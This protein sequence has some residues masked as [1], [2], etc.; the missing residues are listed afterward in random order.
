MFPHM[1]EFPMTV[2]MPKNSTV[3][4]LGLVVVGISPEVRIISTTETM[5][6]CGSYHTWDSRKL[7]FVYFFFLILFTYKEES[8]FIPDMRAM[9]Q[10]SGEDVEPVVGL[11]RKRPNLL[12]ELREEEEKEYEKNNDAFNEN[13]KAQNVDA[14]SRVPPSVEKG[15]LTT[16]P[17]A[18]TVFETRL[19]G[20]GI[21][22]P[23]DHPR[24]I[25][26][27]EEQKEITPSKRKI[28]Y[29]DL[30]GNVKHSLSVHNIKMRGTSAEVAAERKAAGHVKTSAA[31]MGRDQMHALEGCAIHLLLAHIKTVLDKEECAE[32]SFEPVFDG[33]RA[34]L[35]AHHSSF[36]EVY[37][38]IQIKSAQ[39]QFGKQT[40]YSL[41]KGNYEDWMYCISIGIRNYVLVEPENVD[42]TNVPGA[43]IY[44]MW[45][46]GVCVNL[47]P[48]PATTYGPV[49]PAKRC[50]F[51]HD[52][53]GYAKPDAFI[54][55]MLENI[56]AWKH[57]F[58]SDQILYDTEVVNK[59]KID[60]KKKKEVRGLAEL[61]KALPGLRAP[62]RQN[63]TVDSVWERMGISNKTASIA[64]KIPTQRFFMLKVHKY[65]HFCHWVIASYE[66]KNRPD[67]NY[68]KVAVIPAASVYRNE[69]K[70]FCWNE[71]KSST[72]K[73]VKLFDL[74]TEGDAL[75][76]HL[77]TK[78]GVS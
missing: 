34:D 54:R 70:Y 7:Y 63:E 56:K 72:M 32:W 62:W 43:K 48:R 50:F 37:V 33:L 39:I 27:W 40:N 68:K 69:N 66:D 53:E 36:P 67:K 26:F 21:P 29:T 17:I 15:T 28:L 73:D 78:S 45:D 41:Q 71:L 49:E 6:R 22:L 44:E 4:D 30:E 75:R 55:Q 64:N 13:R 51:I 60:E 46:L 76:K 10:S 8:R 19:V 61:A 52:A 1:P 14:R 35:M 25:K 12:H 9:E 77:L 20:K 57:R 3:H 58:T 38:P 59:K 11:K 23:P 47:Q 2:E 24:Q 5:C 42:D 16:L 31:Q 74:E 65:D 18:I